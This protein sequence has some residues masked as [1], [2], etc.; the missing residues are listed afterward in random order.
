MVVAVVSDHPTNP[1]A[2]SHAAA[3][4]IRPYPLSVHVPEATMGYKVVCRPAILLQELLEESQ[5]SP[6]VGVQASDPQMQGTG[7]AVPPS[8]CAQRGPVK[9]P[10][11]KLLEVLHWLP[12]E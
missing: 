4:S 1:A 12:S 11:V 2:A 9:V 6:V 8:T 10:T 7:L 5:K 3:S